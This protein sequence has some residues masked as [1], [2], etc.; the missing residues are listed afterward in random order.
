MRKGRLKEL[1]SQ[2][3]RFGYRRLGLLLARQGV[4][5]ARY[6]I[7]LE[8]AEAVLDA[9]RAALDD[10]GHPVHVPVSRRAFATLSGRLSPGSRQ[11]RFDRQPSGRVL[12]PGKRRR[13]F[14]DL[15]SRHAPNLPRT[16]GRG[17]KGAVEP[18]QPSHPSQIMTT[19]TY[20][21]M[22][23][24][25]EQRAALALANALLPVFALERCRILPATAHGAP[26]PPG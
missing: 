6:A 17:Q 3:R 24:C 11:R 2:R 22:R 16:G 25:V 19:G 4:R 7:A 5:K 21:S 20:P 1:A 14:P 15:G 23:G 26:R 12:H 8:Q 13:H 10:E 18:S 9:R